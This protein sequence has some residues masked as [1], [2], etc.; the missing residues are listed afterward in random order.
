MLNPELN[1][2]T[3]RVTRLLE[4]KS[5]GIGLA[6]YK[7]ALLACTSDVTARKN[8]NV[9]NHAESPALAVSLF[10]Q[11]WQGYFPGK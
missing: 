11:S 9:D 5:S 4:K 8:E 10:R 2:I 3:K 7:Q 6:R 1:Q